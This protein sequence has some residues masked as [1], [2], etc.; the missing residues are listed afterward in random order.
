[1]LVVNSYELIR[2]LIDV[3]FLLVAG[4]ERIHKGLAF[5]V[6]RHGGEQ[7][8]A[9]LFD[10]GVRAVLHE[11]ARAD[12]LHQR[13]NVGVVR[14]GSGGSCRS[15][16]SAVLHRG[17]ALRRCLR[18]VLRCPLNHQEKCADINNDQCKDRFHDCL[19]DGFARVCAT[20]P[21]LGRAVKRRECFA[22]QSCHVVYWPTVQWA[23]AE[24][25]AAHAVGGSFGLY[26]EM[27]LHPGAGFAIR[28]PYWLCM[29]VV[30]G[31]E[32][33]AASIYCK[34]WFPGTPSWIW[35]GF[36]S[37]V[38]LYV[39][40]TNIGSLGTFEFWLSM[41]KVV[42]IVA[43]LILGTALL[44]G[45]GFPKIGFANYTAQGGF[46]PNG[47]KGV[48]LV[49]VLGLFSFFGIEVVGSTAGEAANSKAA[50]P[51]ALR[52]TLVGPV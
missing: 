43:F 47:W 17:R 16:R 5:V 4:G 48:G 10:G 27:Y 38:I 50:V 22:G 11:V 8:F 44:S 52:N 36:F 9:A 39:N 41:I 45:V 23:M 18:G 26:A 46:L 35:I 51:K 19:R 14:R 34:F 28:L 21:I 1:M 6:V 20:N 13:T 40:S 42:T 12:Q 15:R 49:G 33:V 3:E 32:V 30:V 25:A 29:M 31:S 24:M 37:L 7:F 2:Y